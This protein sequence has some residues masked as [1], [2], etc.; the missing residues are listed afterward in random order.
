MTNANCSYRWATGST[1][2]VTKRI[3]SRCVV[4]NR[5]HCLNWHYLLK[6]EK[7]ELTGVPTTQ[8][9]VCPQPVSP[10]QDHH[11][12]AEDH[13]PQTASPVP[14]SAYSCVTCRFQQYMIINA[15]KQPVSHKMKHATITPGLYRTCMPK[16]HKPGEPHIT[17]KFCITTTLGTAELCVLVCVLGLYL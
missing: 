8:W 16:L 9:L 6:E 11:L 5:L 12:T 14:S 7:V 15:K 3:D 10:S 2:C 17:H 4:L 1:V 13:L